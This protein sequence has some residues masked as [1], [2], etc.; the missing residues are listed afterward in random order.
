VSTEL[1]WATCSHCGYAF[2]LNPFAA[3]VVL[4]HH[5]DRVHGGNLLVSF[6]LAS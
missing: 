1:V 5:R 2:H 4:A 3:A 6:T